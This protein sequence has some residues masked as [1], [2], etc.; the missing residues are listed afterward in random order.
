[1]ARVMAWAA[2]PVQPWAALVITRAG[3]MPLLPMHIN[4]WQHR[5]V[6]CSRQWWTELELAC[7]WLHRWA[8]QFELHWNGIRC[9]RFFLSPTAVTYVES[10]GS[11]RWAKS[12]GISGQSIAATAAKFWCTGKWGRY[13]VIKVINWIYTLVVHN[14]ADSRISVG[15]A[16]VLFEL[17]YSV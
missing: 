7:L 8:T 5:W 4:R 2:V 9:I 6:N 10:S 15:A 12:Y 1:M 13:P 17:W 3:A 16:R 14:W 11:S